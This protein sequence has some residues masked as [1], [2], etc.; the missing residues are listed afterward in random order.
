MNW[1]LSYVSLFKGAVLFQNPRV[2]VIFMLKLMGAFG[3]VFQ[4]PVVLMFL[5]WVGLLKSATMKRSWRHA[6]VGISVIGM[7]VTPSNDAFTML[8]MVIPVVFLYVGSIGLVQL[9]ER[10]SM[11]AKEGSN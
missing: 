5:A 8:I 2:Y 4:L 10:R 11:R 1:F 9:M 3:L 6:V 7:I